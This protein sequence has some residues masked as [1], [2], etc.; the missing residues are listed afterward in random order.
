MSRQRIGKK[1]FTCFL[2]M[3]F[4]AC[5]QMTKDDYLI[6][7]EDFVVTVEERNK[8]NKT[9]NWDEIDKKYERLNKSMY[10]EF[11]DELAF[12]DQAKIGAYRLRY[13]I[14]RNQKGVLD[15]LFNSQ[16]FQEIKSKARS[17]IENGLEKDL[18]TLIQEAEK[19]GEEFGQ[20]VEDAVEEVKRELEEK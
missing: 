1:I 17:Y 12:S 19:V 3:A 13:N 18:E 2:L 7:F 10:A 15:A 16:D 11:K 14:Q 20:A 6:E 5:S 9:M 8:A 4:I